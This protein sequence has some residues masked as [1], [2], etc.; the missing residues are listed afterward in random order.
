MIEELKEAET[1]ANSSIGF[2]IIGVL[3]IIAGILVL[4]MD[5]ISENIMPLFR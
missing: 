1:M 4:G 2:R 3:F 5:F